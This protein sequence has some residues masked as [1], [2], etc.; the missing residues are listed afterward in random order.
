MSSEVSR[1]TL[2]EACRRLQ[3]AKGDLAEARA[4]YNDLLRKWQK[5]F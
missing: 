3:N 5:G 1:R 4:K 2:Q